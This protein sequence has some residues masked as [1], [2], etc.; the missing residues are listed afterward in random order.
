MQKPRVSV[1]PLPGQRVLASDRISV[2]LFGSLLLPPWVEGPP[3]SV[4]AI[5]PFAVPP[6][7]ASPDPGS[8]PLRSEPDLL[9]SSPGSLAGQLSASECSSTALCSQFP[10]LSN[11]EKWYLSF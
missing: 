1:T 3:A 5:F 2:L 11:E 7:P 9:G 4:P 8:A 6:T 10:Y